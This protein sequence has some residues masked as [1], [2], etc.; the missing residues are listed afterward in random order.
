M[1]TT[2]NIKLVPIH[3]Y[4]GPERAFG[5]YSESRKIRKEIPSKIKGT[6]GLTF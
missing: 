2:P 3:M 1:E 5:Q 6:C 4:F